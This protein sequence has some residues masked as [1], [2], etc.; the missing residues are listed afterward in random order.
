[1]PD[2]L[3]NP[4]SLMIVVIVYVATNAIQT[5]S[6]LLAVTVMGM[7]LANQRFVSI[8]HIY[9]FKE[10][11]RVLLISSLFIILAARL[12]MA[13]IGLADPQSWIFVLFLIIAVRPAMVF[14]S[15]IG[16]KV[17]VPEKLFVSW[18]A[19]RGIVAA[20]VIS[21]FAIRLGEL[22]FPQYE[23]LVPLTFQVIIGTVAIYG[24]TANLAARVLKVSSKSPQGVLFAGA[25]PW[26]QEI[27]EMLHNQ[28]FNVI[29]VDSNWNNI[30]AARKKGLRSY[31]SDILSENL[32][33]DIDL[34][35]I[36]RLLGMTPNDEVNSLAALHFEDAFDKQEVYQ[37]PPQGKLDSA[38]KADY[39][40][41]L[42]GRFLF[43]E[44]ATYQYLTSRFFTGAIVKKTPITEEFDI[45]SFNAMYNYSALPLFV[46]HESGKLMVCTAEDEIEFKPGQ[47]LISVVDPREKD[48]RTTKT[49]KTPEDEQK[50]ES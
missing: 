16:Q 22:G 18:M 36:G 31:Y 33:S 1:M 28:D 30:K 23:A 45:D 15:T 40:K 41:H 21:V 29:M 3:Q 50:T 11:L 12:P 2:F 17:S 47:I 27:A 7:A 24:L 43:S 34:D 8:K 19:P 13:D 14:L 10:N 44:D 38:Q 35:G 20:A 26:V 37:L 48:K 39:P 5:E 4:V 25:S 46:I 42:R 49:S 32:M 9:E 6:G